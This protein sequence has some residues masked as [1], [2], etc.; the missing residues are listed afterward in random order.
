MESAEPFGEGILLTWISKEKPV[1]EAIEEARLRVKERKE[2]LEAK[3]LKEANRIVF[4][5]G[6]RCSILDVECSTDRFSIPLAEAGNIVVGLDLSRQCLL[7]AK[8]WAKKR[9]VK[10]DLVVGTMENLPF[11]PHFEKFNL[12]L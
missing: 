3:V 10:L 6:K 12:L 1:D 8:N 11:K 7:Q 9:N 4:F 2:K 5:L